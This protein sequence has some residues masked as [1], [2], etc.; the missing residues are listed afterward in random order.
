MVD[1]VEPNFT[2]RRDA[3]ELI[4]NSML[5]DRY[6]FSG[7]PALLVN[8][9]EV[10]IYGIKSNDGLVSK[11]MNPVIVPSTSYYS[12]F[13]V[14]RNQC[15]KIC[16]YQIPSFVG[17]DQADVHT[18][19]SA[20][21]AEGIAMSLVSVAEAPKTLLMISKALKLLRHPFREAQQLLQ[22]S[23]SALRDP[24]KRREVVDLAS[25]LW[26]EGRYGWRPFVYDVMDHVEALNSGLRPIRM[27]VRSK[28]PQDE[29]TNVTYSGK[30]VRAGEIWS[31]LTT[32]AEFSYFYRCGQTADYPVRLSS[33]AFNYG[34]YDPVGTLW[35]LI[36][37]SFVVDWFVNLGDM[38]KSFQAYALVDERVGWTT[39]CLDVNV[40][41]STAFNRGSYTSGNY[42][43]VQTRPATNDL[44]WTETYKRRQ[45]IKIDSFLPQLGFG[46]G[47]NVLKTVDLALI[48]RSLYKSR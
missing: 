9:Y 15:N 3:G 47:L 35:E 48:L 7:K 36:P 20:E 46:S 17:D 41:C 42:Y 27:T 4:C 5:H 16:G 23:R 13:T 31:I 12:N 30:L 40:S 32:S 22:L 1:V 44:I 19:L 28:V 33:S 11:V 26:L 10:Y 29:G 39:V 14:I 18:S 2:E 45:R 38:L 21:L 37:L 6:S 43:W 25:N 34:L 8:D 24:E